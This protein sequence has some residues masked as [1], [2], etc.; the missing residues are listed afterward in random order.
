M[1]NDMFHSYTDYSGKVLVQA[2]ILHKLEF[3]A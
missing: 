2:A 3:L 1:L